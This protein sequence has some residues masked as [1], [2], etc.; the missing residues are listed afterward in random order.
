MDSNKPST[1]N[2]VNQNPKPENAIVLSKDEVQKLL[3]ASPEWLRFI[4]RVMVSTGMRVG[5]TAYM[6]GMGGH[7][8]Q[9]G[10]D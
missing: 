3:A 8:C 4:I 9:P 1:K 6:D 10:P 7:R 2:Q 5:E